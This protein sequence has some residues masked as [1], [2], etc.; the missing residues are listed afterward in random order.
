MLKIPVFSKCFELLRHVIGCIVTDDLRGDS[1]NRKLSLKKVNYVFRIWS[2]EFLR[3]KESTVT[4]DEY[5]ESFAVK[6]KQISS[7][8]FKGAR[9]NLM[10]LH[11][12]FLLMGLC[13]VACGT[14]FD[15]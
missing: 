13:A 2:T 12:F 11:W 6:V 7:D 5:N 14:F 3:I 1:M 8:E 10:K 9:R 15:I 4:V